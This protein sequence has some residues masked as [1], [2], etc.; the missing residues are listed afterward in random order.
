MKKGSTTFL[1]FV[2]IL[3]AGAVLT[4]LLA[5]PHFEGRAG[6][7]DFIN[8]YMDPV[9]GYIY[10]SSIPFFLALVQAFKLLGLIEHKKAF[11]QAAVNHLKNIKFC[12]LGLAGFAT[13]GMPFLFVAAQN[14]DAPGLVLI[15]GVFIFA[16]LVVA[17]GAAVFQAL[18][19]NAVDIKNE[20]DLTV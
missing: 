15:A 16:T 8:V 13:I 7:L 10:L 18:L 4:G 2:L 14:D 11:T 12:A 1:K 9:I 6:N 20:N 17:T 19:Q 3:I 5:F